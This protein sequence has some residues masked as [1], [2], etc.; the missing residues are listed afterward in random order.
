MY[1]HEQLEV[2]QRVERE[3]GVANPGVAVVVVPVT[4]DSLGKRCRRRGRNSTR[5]DVR[6]QAERER[7][8]A[9]DR[10]PGSLDACVVEPSLPVVGRVAESS[11][12]PVATRDRNRLVSGRPQD[13]RRAEALL[14]LEAAGDL[15]LGVTGL[16]GVE[17]IDDQAQVARGRSNGAADA[18]DRPLVA[19][20]SG[21]E[22]W[23]DPPAHRYGAAHALDA[24]DELEPRQE[25]AVVECDRVGH[26]HGAAGRH[27]GRL[28][29]VRIRHVLALGAEARLWRK[30]ESTATLGVEKAGEDRLG[31]QAR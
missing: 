20:F 23:C 14:E 27:E 19:S 11:L 7:A 28:Q 3:G 24:A 31:V 18:V 21:A 12:G 17:R 13:Q 6:E 1:L 2:D 9:D 26:P 22:P 29:Y 4:C 8:A 25:T 15:A 30:L 16:A 5:R 10:I